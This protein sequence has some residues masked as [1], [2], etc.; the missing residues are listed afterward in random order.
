MVLFKNCKLFFIKTDSMGLYSG[1]GGIILLTRIKRVAVAS[2]LA[3]AFTLCSY[4]LVN[5]TVRSNL[6]GWILAEGSRSNL[7]KFSLCG[8][9]PTI[10]AKKNEHKARFLVCLK[11]GYRS[12]DSKILFLKIKNREFTGK[13]IKNE[14]FLFI[15]MSQNQAI[16][17]QI[18]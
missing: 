6:Q 13:F 7:T 9:H 3:A 10:F 4:L 1:E 15:L 11:L 16:S 17:L 5:E 14:C 2:W 8:S 12:F 18:P